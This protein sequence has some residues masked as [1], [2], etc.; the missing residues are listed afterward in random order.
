MRLW[1]YVN[2][3]KWALI[4]YSSN[5]ETN[6]KELV[7]NYSVYSTSFYDGHYNIY[8][9]SGIF[10][11][12]GSKLS[13][14]VRKINLSGYNDWYI[15]SQDETA[16]VANTIKNNPALDFGMDGVYITSSI[17]DDKIDNIRYIYSQD[18]TDGNDFGFVE[19][20]SSNDLRDG[21]F[22]KKYKIKLAR[23]IYL[24]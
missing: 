17:T 9:D 21:K 2:L 3:L 14:N 23:R 16:F 4:L 24:S 11:G 19:L 18:F 20:V 6:E 10:F 22:N 15:M 1:A 13:G 7:S 12:M 5:L 8:G